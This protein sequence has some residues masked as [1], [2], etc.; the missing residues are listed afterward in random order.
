MKDD[1]D[2]IPLKQDRQKPGFKSAPSKW[3]SVDTSL[4]EE[5]A[6]TTSKWEL[7]E[8]DDEDKR[9]VDRYVKMH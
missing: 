4:L 8:K 1:L 7:L 9:D 2:G 3:E 5:Q 6:M